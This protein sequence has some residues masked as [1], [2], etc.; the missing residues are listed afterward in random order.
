MN[1]V[2]TIIA[3]IIIVA[4]V[5]GAVVLAQTAYQHARL[6]RRF[7]KEYDRALEARGSRK[8]AER[9]LRER[10]ERIRNMQI[11]P[12]DPEARDRFA[13]LWTRVQEQFVDT[14]RDAVKNADA[15]V[16]QVM[17]ERGYPAE[18]YDQQAADLSV[19]HGAT[20]EHYREAH[21]IASRAS[22]GHVST[23]DLRQAV[24]HYRTL[25][26][27]LLQTDDRKEARR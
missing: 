12:L 3:I 15:L 4:A 17:A 23:E 8:G 5:A 7:G 25:F 11:R 10:E 20:L 6:R 14:P 13:A 19:E 24:V 22:A 27:D 9:E 2:I 26:E 16:T 21:E 18:S 1:T